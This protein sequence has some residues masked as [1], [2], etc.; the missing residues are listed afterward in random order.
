MSL[1]DSKRQGS[2]SGERTRRFSLYQFILLVKVLLSVLGLSHNKLGEVTSYS[3]NLVVSPAGGPQ[4][5]L[6]QQAIAFFSLGVAA[7]ATATVAYTAYSKYGGST[8]PVAS[9]GGK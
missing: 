4:W 1:E 7:A 3:R 8:S 6:S 9:K 2:R 5:S